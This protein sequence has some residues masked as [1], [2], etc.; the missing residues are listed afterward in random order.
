MQGISTP[1][2]FQHE[3][4][5][6]NCICVACFHFKARTNRTMQRSNV[7]DLKLQNII[8][9]LLVPSRGTLHIEF[10]VYVS[11]GAKIRCGLKALWKVHTFLDPNSAV[12]FYTFQSQIHPSKHKLQFRRRWIQLC[13]EAWAP[14]AC[15]QQDHRAFGQPRPQKMHVGRPWQPLDA[16]RSVPCRHPSA[17]CFSSMRL[18]RE[19]HRIP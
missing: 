5:T 14:W 3:I 17:H 10:Q 18:S 16:N 11:I 8:K 12:R 9:V 2:V 1:R 13:L 15:E 6:W 19:S 7:Q 4:K